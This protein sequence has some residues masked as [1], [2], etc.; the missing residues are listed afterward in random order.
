MTDVP[1]D[2]LSNAGLSPRERL[3]RIE[4]LLEKIDD[5][6]DT[7]ADAQRL[8]TLELIVQSLRVKIWAFGIVS[9]VLFA[10]AGG[11]AGVIV[12]VI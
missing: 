3:E 1:T 6:L 12:R 2:G 7:K 11:V 8:Y 4:H 10:V 5:K 9:A